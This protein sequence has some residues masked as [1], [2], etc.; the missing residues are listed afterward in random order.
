MQIQLGIRLG[1]LNEH[2]TQGSIHIPQV[3]KGCF[4]NCRL[5]HAGF[6]ASIMFV[7][8]HTVA[9][10]PQNTGIQRKEISRGLGMKCTKA[11]GIERQGRTISEYDTKNALTRPGDR[12]QQYPCAMKPPGKIRL[13]R[14]CITSPVH[15]DKPWREEPCTNERTAPR[16]LHEVSIGTLWE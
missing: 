15:Q 14:N 5:A 8:L 1:V 10:A 2:R 9:N 3:C 6:R 12:M 13:L 16:T 7:P 11:I 4:F